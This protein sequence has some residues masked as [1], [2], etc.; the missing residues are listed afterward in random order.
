MHFEKLHRYIRKI[1]F[2]KCIS[3][4]KCV[5]RWIITEMSPILLLWS[6][7]G[8]RTQICRR[9]RPPGYPWWPE[10]TVSMSTLES[11]IG[12]RYKISRN[13]SPQRFFRVAEHVYHVRNGLR[14]TRC[15][16]RLLLTSS[17]GTLVLFNLA[18]FI[19]LIALIPFLS[20]FK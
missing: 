10:W 4:K 5:T 8:R 20:K 9:Q 2:H 18:L 13:S 15:P 12:V 14:G 6:F 19:L 1:H 3:N 17:L 16:G 7:Y 11:F